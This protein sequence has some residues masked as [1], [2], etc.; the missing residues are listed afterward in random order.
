M[1]GFITALGGTILVVIVAAVVITIGFLALLATTFTGGGS[2]YI[3]FVSASSRPYAVASV[4]SELNT[5]DR[6]FLEEAVEIAVSNVTNASAQR[7]SGYLKD[8]FTAY[9]DDKPFISV[10]IKRSDDELL[11][12]SNTDNQCGDNLEGYCVD[13]SAAQG[14]GPYLGSSFGQN[15]GAGR[16]KIDDVHYNQNKCDKGLC[17]IEDLTNGH[18]GAGLRTCGPE[19]GEKKGICDLSIYGKCAAGRVNYP[20]E[21]NECMSGTVCCIPANQAEDIVFSRFSTAEVPL[22]YRD[23]FLGTMEVSAV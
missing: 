18:Y 12:V 8:F 1:R 17:C 23:G 10:I 15:C 5:G 7:A 11:S 13:S 9:K 4:I 20:S 2:N 3:E 21:S 6:Q 19:R 16:R 14:Q 22:L